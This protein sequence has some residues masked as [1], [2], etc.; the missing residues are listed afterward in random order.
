VCSAPLHGPMFEL[1][2]Q[3]KAQPDSYRAAVFLAQ[4]IAA[5]RK[6]Q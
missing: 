3:N 1:A 2:N 5:C 6:A 4:D